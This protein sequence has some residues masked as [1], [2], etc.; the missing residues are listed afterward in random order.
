MGLLLLAGIVHGSLGEKS[1]DLAG[2]TLFSSR[3]HRVLLVETI[4]FVWSRS[5]ATLRIEIAIL[6]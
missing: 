2:M 6:V 3:I 5:C 1:A 4:E